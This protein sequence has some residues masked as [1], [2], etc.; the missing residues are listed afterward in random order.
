MQ[1]SINKVCVILQWQAGEE[2]KIVKGGKD[3]FIEE[4][5]TYIV[6]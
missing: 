6:F 4:M 3:Y 2:A 1:A 5:L